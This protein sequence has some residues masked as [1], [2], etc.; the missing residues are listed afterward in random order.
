MYVCMNTT[1]HGTV[2]PGPDPSAVPARPHGIACRWLAAIVLSGAV[3]ALSL[4]SPEPEGP[5]APPPGGRS[6]L[7]AIWRRAWQRDEPVPGD[8]LERA[9]ERDR[10]LV[11]R[12][13]SR[14]AAPGRPLSLR[15]RSLAV[16]GWLGDARSAERLAT[17]LLTATD[18][19]FAR[20]A[21]LSALE[22]SGL[23]DSLLVGLIAD[24]DDE[25]RRR[26]ARRMLA[27]GAVAEETRYRAFCALSWGDLRWI[28]QDLDQAPLPARPARERLDEMVARMARD[29]GLRPEFILAVVRAESNFDVRCVSR[30]GAQGLMQLMPATARSVGVDDP[31]DAGQ[32]VV[33]GIRY[34]KSMLR[35]FG[36]NVALALAAYNAGPTTVDRYGGI[37]PYPETRRYLRR[38]LGYLEG[39][40]RRAL[41]ATEGGGGARRG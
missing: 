12:L 38:V 24:A 40:R 4:A 9:S 33:G 3:T 18:S 35:R 27:S 41:A 1:T 23:E 5:P 2:P 10:E 6:E 31:F 21:A 39:Y 36:G 25:L 29:N 15:L 26:A 28:E 8:W 30:A 11:F 37:P 7:P 19:P 22:G 20:R 13:A 17:I 34:L 16:L 14:D 32:N